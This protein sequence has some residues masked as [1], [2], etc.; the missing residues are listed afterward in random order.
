MMVAVLRI[1]PI[2]PHSYSVTVSIDGA[3]QSPIAFDVDAMGVSTPDEFSRLILPDPR[4]GR[5]VYEA[6][7]AY[8]RNRAD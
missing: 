8:D 4:V 6:I 3:A 1:D 7:L 5:P 2:G